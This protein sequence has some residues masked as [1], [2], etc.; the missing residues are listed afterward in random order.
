[1]REPAA[2]GGPQVGGTPAGNTNHPNNNQ[3]TMTLT[4]MMAQSHNTTQS[5]QLNIIDNNNNNT[6]PNQPTDSF[7]TPWGDPIQPVKS[8]QTVRLALQNLADG[9]NGIT[10]TRTRLSDTSSMKNKLTSS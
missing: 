3:D 10:T 8:P 5:N 4:N 1:M 2:P 7:Y 6:T 9:H